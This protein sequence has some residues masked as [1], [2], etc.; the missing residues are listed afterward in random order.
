[1]ARRAPYKLANGD[2]VPSVTTITSRFKE[3]G[4]LIYWANKQGLEG[5]TL[6]EARTPA[7]V[8]G[9]LAHSLVEAHVNNWAE[10]ELQAP[11]DVIA[12]ARSA[13]ENFL[14]WAEHTRLE[15]VHTEHALVSEEHRFGGRFDAVAKQT[16]G[17]YV[18]IDF[19][20]GSLYLE[21]LLQVAAYRLLWNESYPQFELTDAAHL[22]SFRR[23]TADF[24]HS[25]FGGLD[26]ETDAFLR[27]RGLYDR[28]K[29]IEKRVK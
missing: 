1:M 20:T 8:A 21:H 10:P 14:R 4:G 24:S 3:S 6:D 7:A 23:E 22:L 5:L 9:T 13:F 25:Y 16:D 2:R 18:M 12:K 15:F 17:R 28:V 19:K 26:D 27:M 11:A 29:K